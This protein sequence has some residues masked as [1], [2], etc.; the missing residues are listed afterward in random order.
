M[1]GLTSLGTIHTAIGLVAL[2]AGAYPGGTHS[3]GDTSKE[4]LNADLLAFVK[5]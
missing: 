1:F 4:Q 3:L 2:I 5:N